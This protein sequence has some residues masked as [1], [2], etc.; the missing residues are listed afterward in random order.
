MEEN[1]NSGIAD[2]IYS[3]TAS[4]GRVWALISLIMAIIICIVLIIAGIVIIMKSRKS[5]IVE[6]QGIITAINGSTDPQTK[7]GNPSDNDNI[8]TCSITVKFTI[9]DVDRY[10][11]INYTGSYYYFVGKRVN[12]YIKNDGKY[13]DVSL[14]KPTPAFVGGILI[15]VGLLILGGSIFWY[16]ASRKWKVVAGAEGVSGML[17]LI[18]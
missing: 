9:S 5:E 3:G 6:T 10:A 13:N 11:D 17:H 7:C 4:F 14:D 16:W 15:F 18:R 2:E 8:H 1:K 12:L